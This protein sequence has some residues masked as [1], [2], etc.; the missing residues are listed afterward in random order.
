MKLGWPNSSRYT[1]FSVGL[2][3]VFLV[4][5]LAIEFALARD[6]TAQ[7][8]FGL[9]CVP[10]ITVVLQFRLSWAT[11]MAQ[12]EIVRGVHAE[13]FLIAVATT[14]FV[15]IAYSTMPRAI[16]APELPIWIIYPL[17]W[18]VLGIVATLRDRAAS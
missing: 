4:A 7:V 13:R 17:F 11:L 10:F 5:L 6:W 9:A 12:D 16:G 14:L 15:A 8:R 18:G 1:L 2:W 3:L